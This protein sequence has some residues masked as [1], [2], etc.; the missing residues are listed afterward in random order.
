[1][2]NNDPAE[3]EGRKNVHEEVCFMITSTFGKYWLTLTKELCK[4]LH[5]EPGVLHI[6]VSAVLR[7]IFGSD[8]VDER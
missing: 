8:N 1:M 6:K 3:S 7:Y 5:R 4:I 2:L